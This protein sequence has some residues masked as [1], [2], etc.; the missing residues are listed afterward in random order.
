MAEHVWGP[1]QALQNCSPIQICLTAS[2]LKPKSATQT[3]IFKINSTNEMSPLS[4]KPAA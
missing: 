4:E 1:F 2:F 3:V